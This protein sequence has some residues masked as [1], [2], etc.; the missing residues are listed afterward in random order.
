MRGFRENYD[1]FQKA[2]AEI[3]EIS[4]DNMPVQK[5]WADS[6][7]G[8]PFPIL[9]DFWPHGDTALA[10]DVFNP[11]RGGARRSIFLIDEEGVIRYSE[12][13]VSG[14]PKSEDVLAELAKF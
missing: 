4:C 5:A 8:V 2:G 6:L 11:D 3:L 10:Y 14:I 1:H 7:D 13:F 9:S 12:V